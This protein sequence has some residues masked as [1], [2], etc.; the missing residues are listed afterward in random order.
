MGM[1][2]A[3]KSITQGPKL[4]PKMEPAAWS[5]TRYVGLSF[6]VLAA[7]PAALCVAQERPPVFWEQEERTHS[8]RKWSPGAASGGALSLRAEKKS[9]PL[10]RKRGCSLRENR[11]WNPCVTRSKATAQTDMREQE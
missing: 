7:V 5:S 8:C 11:T 4:T 10:S 3:V 9:G 6:P 1:I 2:P